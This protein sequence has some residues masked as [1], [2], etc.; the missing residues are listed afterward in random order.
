MAN[1]EGL[2]KLIGFLGSKECADLHVLAVEVLGYCLADANSMIVLQGSGCLQQLLSHI[3]ESSD[4]IMKKNATNTLA[5]AAASDC[6][7]LDQLIN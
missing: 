6:K 4:P 5:S 1:G 7:E 3:K 2:S